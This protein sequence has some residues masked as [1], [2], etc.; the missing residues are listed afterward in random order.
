MTDGPQDLNDDLA[1]YY[2]VVLHTHANVSDIG[3][4]RVCFVAGC[5]DWVDAYDKLAAA[6]LLMGD[7]DLW[8]GPSPGEPSR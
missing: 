6:G 1:A 8:G 3:A 5:P 4:C 7:P 2:R